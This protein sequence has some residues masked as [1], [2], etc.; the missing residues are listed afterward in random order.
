MEIIRLAYRMKG[1][2]KYLIK[3]ILIS[4]F[5]ADP[6]LTEALIVLILREIQN[7]VN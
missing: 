2:S 3:C 7:R 1:Y 4:D 5:L 6:S